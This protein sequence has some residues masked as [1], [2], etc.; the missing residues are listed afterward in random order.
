MCPNQLFPLG[1]AQRGETQRKVDPNNMFA[2]PG[3]EVEHQP[4]TTPDDRQQGQRQE[5]QEPEEG[6]NKTT[7]HFVWAKRHLANIARS[8]Q[9]T[10]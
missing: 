8:A 5:M 3:D 6:G 4:Q 7:Q 9:R 2:P 1:F 10:G